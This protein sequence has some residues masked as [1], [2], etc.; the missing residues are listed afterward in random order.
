M[1]TRLILKFSAMALALSSLPLFAATTG[2]VTPRIQVA[3]APTLL[4]SSTTVTFTQLDES[5]MASPE[6][7]ANTASAYINTAGTPLYLQMDS[8]PGLN[9][10]VVAN[11][12]VMTP[13]GANTVSGNNYIPYT[14]SFTPCG[15]G[16]TITFAGVG[17]ANR[18]QI[19]AANTI[20][21]ACVIG[22]QGSLNFTRGAMSALPSSGAYSGGVSFTLS[23][24]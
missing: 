22:G 17:A 20:A 15:G 11:N 10:L 21:T 13:N 16:A 5:N 9:N 14:V 1:K 3:S 24:T 7:K 4:I 12:P 23:V 2:M 19:P 8:A 18:I 6:S